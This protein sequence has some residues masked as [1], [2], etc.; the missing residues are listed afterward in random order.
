MTKSS[1]GSMI[2]VNGTKY[3]IVNQSVGVL[4][5]VKGDNCIVIKT[6]KKCFLVAVGPKGKQSA[7]IDEINKFGESLSKGGY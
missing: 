4:F 3:M 1:V 7:L 2:P 5:G 6:L